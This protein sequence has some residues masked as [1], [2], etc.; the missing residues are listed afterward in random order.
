[1]GSHIFGLYGIRQFL[2]FTVSKRTR[3]FVLQMK[4]KVLFIQSK[5][6]SI[7]KNRK[8]VSRKI[9]YLAKSDYDGAIIGHRIEYNGVGALRGQRHIPSKKQ[10]KYLTGFEP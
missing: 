8:L 5:N 7:H 3:M 6:E 2:I 10:P 9:S 4:S 1:M